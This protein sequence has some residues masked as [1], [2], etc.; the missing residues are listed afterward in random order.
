[1]SGKRIADGYLE[2]RTAELVPG[3]VAWFIGAGGPMGQMHVQ[4]AVLHARP[5]KRIVATD[6]DA[7]RLQSLADRFAAE[8]R[9]RGVEL[10]TLNPKEMAAGA[11][12]AE[13]RRLSDDRGFDDILSLVPVPALIEHAADLLAEEGWLNIFA[14]VARGTMAQ[15]DVNLVV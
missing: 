4:R 8:A 2:S 12:D 6:I 3:G 13:L 7:E 10:V 15:L 5:P 9:A 1:T 11:F 14:G